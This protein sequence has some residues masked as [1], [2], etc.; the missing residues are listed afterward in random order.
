LYTQEKLSNTVNE[1]KRTGLLEDPYI[2][3]LVIVWTV[4][5]QTWQIFRDFGVP[6]YSIGV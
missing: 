4:T 6:N 3:E 2:D 1:E 5:V